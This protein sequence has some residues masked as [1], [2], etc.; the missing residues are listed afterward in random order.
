MRPRLAGRV[1]ATHSDQ[2]EGTTI[3]GRKV[4][5]RVMKRKPPPKHAGVAGATATQPLGRQAR[6]GPDCVH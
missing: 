5:P 2:E 1:G 6:S 4:R 3:E